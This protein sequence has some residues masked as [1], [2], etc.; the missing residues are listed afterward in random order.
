MLLPK[1]LIAHRRRQIFKR[2]VLCTILLTLLATALV[3][4]GDAIF[5]TK[6]PSFDAT[7]YLA[8][9][10][11]P[12]AITGVPFKLI[13]RTYSGVIKQVEIETTA[14]VDNTS[15]RPTYNKLYT[16]NT[17]YLTVE[18]TNGKVIRKK[19]YSGKAALQEH[20]DTYHEGDAVFH[21]YGTKTTVVLPTKSDTTICCAVCGA[22]ND[23]A[24]T[25]CHQCQHT[26]VKTTI[27][28][29]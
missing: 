9:L 27:D 28:T 13:D 26:L 12:F 2:V 21:L 29:I 22:S 19:A 18:L 24:Y 23:V 14:A 17:I 1:D 4:W 7:C 8:I 25:T 16:K 3:L 6:Y 11:L 15:V 5:N 20:L 10:L